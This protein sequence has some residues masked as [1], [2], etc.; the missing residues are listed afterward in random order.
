MMNLRRILIAVIVM[1]AVGVVVHAQQPTP[2][3]SGAARPDQQPQAA[4]PPGQQ[5]PAQTKAAQEGFVPVEQ[6]PQEGDR[7]PAP[8]L[9]GTAYAFVWVALFVYIW[10]VWRRLASVERELQAVSRRIGTGSRPS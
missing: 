4:P 9:V 7:I 2:P 1:V 6:L 5:T 8:A 3:A 10:S